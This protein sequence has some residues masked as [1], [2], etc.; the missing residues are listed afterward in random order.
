MCAF[1]D[2]LVDSAT[3]E[4]SADS[5]ADG[6][7]CPERRKLEA[8]TQQERQSNFDSAG[9]KRSQHLRECEFFIFAGVEQTVHVQFT[10]LKVRRPSLSVGRWGKERHGEHFDTIFFTRSHLMQRDNVYTESK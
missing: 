1:H 9:G 10:R 7:D 8:R 2:M 3:V 5:D 4:L 6:H